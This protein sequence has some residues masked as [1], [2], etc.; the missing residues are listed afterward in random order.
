ML[1]TSFSFSFCLLTRCEGNSHGALEKYKR[2]FSEQV[3]GLRKQMEKTTL[4]VDGMEVT[5]V[6]FFNIIYFPF[7]YIHTYIHT[8]MHAC[9]HAY[10]HTYIQTYIQTYKHTYIHTYSTV[11]PKNN[12]CARTSFCVRKPATS[13][14]FLR[15]VSKL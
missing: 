6:S 2:Q 7:S 4:I 12:A 14:G 13:C 11:Q 5:F 1:L 3:Q 8:Y 9:M 10:I 15:V